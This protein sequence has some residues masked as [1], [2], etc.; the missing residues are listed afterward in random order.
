MLFTTIESLSKDVYEQRRSTGSDAFPFSTPSRYQICIAKC[1]YA[2]RDKLPTNLGITTNPRLRK[3]HF[4][5]TRVA[6][7]RLW[8]P[9][10]LMF[11][12]SF[13]TCMYARPYESNWRKSG[14]LQVSLIYIR[15]SS[16]IFLLC[17]V[18]CI[19]LF[20]QASTLFYLWVHDNKQHH[21][22]TASIFL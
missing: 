2:Y 15:Y 5:L 9:L 21:K 19:N 8:E 6:V 22:L 16:V 7:K 20:N 14:G 17:T 12:L 18:F 10:N 11:E 13:S 3:V 1:L 4:R